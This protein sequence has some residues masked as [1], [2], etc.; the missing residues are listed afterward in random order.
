MY[1]YV[2]IYIYV[3][4]IYIFFKCINAEIHTIQAQV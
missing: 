2:Y 3:Y 1:V 4:T